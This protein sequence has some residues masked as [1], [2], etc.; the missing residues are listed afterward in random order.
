MLLLPYKVQCTFP[1][2]FFYPEKSLLD[3]EDK[4]IFKQGDVV[5]V[6]LLKRLCL[7]QSIF[8]DIL[9]SMVH[10]YKG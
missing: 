8:H 1:I 10:V 2:P 4:Q 7:D 5:V 6:V 3:F 9:F